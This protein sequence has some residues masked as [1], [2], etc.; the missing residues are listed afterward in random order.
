M[1]ATSAP[2]DM[3]VSYASTFINNSKL[4]AEFISYRPDVSRYENQLLSAGANGMIQ[5]LTNPADDIRSTLDNK[6]NAI[7]YLLVLF[8]VLKDVKGNEKLTSWVLLFLDGMLEDNRT[9]VENLV[10][11]QRSHKKDK[12][13]DLIS[14]LLDFITANNLQDCIQRDTAAHVLA[15]LIEATGYKHCAQQAKSFLAWI[16]IPEKNKITP[17]AYSSSLMYLI[18]VNELAREFYERNGMGQLSKML[19]TECLDDY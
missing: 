3:I 16:V 9:R 5:Y 1:S 6:G 13:E 10:A 14:I 8:Q 19:E 2:K 11:I 17:A 18:K 15:M 7:E 12:K 4:R